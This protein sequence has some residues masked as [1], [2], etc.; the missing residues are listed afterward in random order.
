MC[1]SGNPRSRKL[2]S[3]HASVPVKEVMILGFHAPPQ[4]QNPV[5]SYFDCVPRK[6][7][8][9]AHT[10]QTSPVNTSRS[11]SQQR[12]SAFHRSFARANIL[13]KGS[14]SEASRTSICWG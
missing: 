9:F 11:K 10:L 8:F 7:C 14:D 2:R 5:P 6:F 13:C 12:V 1:C 3:P 4:S